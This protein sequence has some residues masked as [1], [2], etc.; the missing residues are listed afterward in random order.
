[1]NKNRKILAIDFTRYFKISEGVTTV[2]EQRRE[3]KEGGLHDR[4][5]L[6][7]E[8]NRSV[9]LDQ[10]EQGENFINSFVS[11]STTEKRDSACS[12]ASVDNLLNTGRQMKSENPVVK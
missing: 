1:M 4:D 7:V 9:V 6:F 12:K 5:N 10:P 2:L 3:W 11:D 8:A